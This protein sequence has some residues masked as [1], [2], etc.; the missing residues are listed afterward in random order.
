FGDRNS[1]GDHL[2][3]GDGVGGVECGVRASGAPLVPGGNDE[4]LLQS[5]VATHRPEIGPAGPSGQI[6]HDRIVRTAAPDHQSLVVSVDFDHYQFSDPVV[7]SHD[8]SGGG[9]ADH[10]E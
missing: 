4:V 6:Q 5:D 2:F 3:E 9:G 1:V 8:R 7:A 10:E